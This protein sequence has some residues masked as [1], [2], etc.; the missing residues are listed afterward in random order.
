M[1]S[2]EVKHISTTNC[3]RAISRVNIGGTGLICWQIACESVDDL[4]NASCERSSCQQT[5]K[6]TY[7]QHCRQYLWLQLERHQTEEH[8]LDEADECLSKCQLAGDIQTV[9][10]RV[11][12]GARGNQA[13]I[14]RQDTRSK[15]EPVQVDGIVV[16]AVSQQKGGIHW[17]VIRWSSTS[18]VCWRG[19]E[20][21][22]AD[23]C[24]SSWMCWWW[25]NVGF[26]CVVLIY[27][28]IHTI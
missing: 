21:I 10:L 4:L 3:S 9:E 27:D 1:S 14:R 22:Q 16:S 26:C 11:V 12:C 15:N 24:P 5:S 19:E 18:A 23:V 6:M 2:S 8:K 20:K 17:F 25:T 7:Q 28:W 13:Q